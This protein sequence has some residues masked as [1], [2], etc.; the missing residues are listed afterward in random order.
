[1]C[2]IFGLV[3]DTKKAGQTVFTALKELEYRGYDSW[4]VAGVPLHTNSTKLICSKKVGKILDSKIGRFA[5]SQIA[6]GHTRW[7]THGGVTVQNAH[8]H[9]DS[10]QQVA[11]VHN[12]IIENFA[13]LR[14][15]LLAKG[16][17][18]RS[19]T[20]SE[21]FAHL[22]TEEL[23]TT[24]FPEAFRR[25]FMQL[26]GLNAVVA[27][28]L[29]EPSI[30]AARNG[31]PLL[32]GFGKKSHFISSDPAG[33][34]PHTKQVYYLEDGEYAEIQA[35]S[36]IIKTVR[37]NKQQKIVTKMLD[38]NVDQVSKGSFEHFMLKEIYEQPKIL[39]EIAS[40]GQANAERIARCITK[41]YGS[42]LIGCG[43][44]AY[45]CLAGTYIFSKI[46][47]RHVNWAVGSEFGYQVD[48]LTQKSA[49][50]ALSQS[51]E[52]MDILESVKQ[53]RKKEA[54][55]LAIVNSI[56]SSLYRLAD[57]KLLLGAGPEKAVASTKAF[58]AKIAYLLLIAH[59][60]AGKKDQGAACVKAAAAATQEILTST[61]IN[62]V[63]KISK[64]IAQSEHMF[65]IGR[66]VS[67]PAALEAALKIK[68]ISYIH[69]EGLAAGELKHGAL[70][71]IEKGLPCMVFAPKDETY[72]ATLS[73]AMEVKA[74]GG[75]IIG[76]AEERHEVFDAFI[77]VTDI[78][79]ATLIPNV[80][81]GQLFAYYLS[82]EKK[83]DPD[84]PRNL[85]KSVTVK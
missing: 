52:T 77:P 63:K 70:A 22:L 48:F 76:C 15:N 43:T 69:A 34:I 57:E 60:L 6:I 27:I 67:Y 4:G 20:D 35:N 83:L 33:L 1:M 53:A 23:K 55:I 44:G 17:V 58:L 14:D 28:K 11:I 66:G 21:V 30:L 16:Y 62:N 64:R 42:Y 39:S 13:Q 25:S 74:R 38:W 56:G 3:G 24:T 47:K 65:V 82:V 9:L 61:H 80:V 18:F 72:Q 71:L 46:A 2:G 68:E 36:V 78:G 54:T 51:G 12:G 84:K 41:S 37:T 59:T 19:E 32:L 73:A 8:P 49:V 50:I 75:Y 29:G 10:E 79:I 26:E 40:S 7:A 81:I 5:E 31:S 45:A 85:A